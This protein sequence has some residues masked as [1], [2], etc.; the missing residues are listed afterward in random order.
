MFVAQDAAGHVVE[1][2]RY[3]D[4]VAIAMPGQR[5]KILHLRAPADDS[6]EQAAIRTAFLNAVAAFPVHAEDEDYRRKVT[7]LLV[8]LLLLQETGLL[9]YE[10][11]RRKVAVPAR[12]AAAVGWMLGAAY[13]HFVYFQ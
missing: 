5:W 7:L 4:E 11:W 12:T 9:L 6:A 1:L 2:A 8:V 10:S 3:R 13:L